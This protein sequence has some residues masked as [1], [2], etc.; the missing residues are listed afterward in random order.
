[1]SFL[2]ALLND[3]CLQL[4]FPLMF[5]MNHS[6]TSVLL[7]IWHIGST[8]ARGGTDSYIVASQINRQKPEGCIQCLCNVCMHVK[9]EN[10]QLE[11]KTF[12]YLPL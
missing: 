11:I 4:L 8:S 9:P 7:S 3:I 2:I 10:Q 12:T 5:A 1:M 6:I